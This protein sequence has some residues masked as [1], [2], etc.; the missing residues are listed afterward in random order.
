MPTVHTFPSL[1]V[2]WQL[3]NSPFLFEESALSLSVSLSIAPLFPISSLFSGLGRVDVGQSCGYHGLSSKRGFWPLLLPCRLVLERIS[4]RGIW[5]SQEIIFLRHNMLAV[6]CFF[7]Y[8]F[9][10]ASM[11]VP[12]RA[13]WRQITTLYA[14]VLVPT[15]GYYK[16]VV[17]GACE[18]KMGELWLEH[19]SLRRGREKRLFALGG[20]RHGIY[21]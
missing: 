9:C 12:H 21:V 6:F 10:M 5:S 17:G 7:K 2:D 18:A 8:T 13:W 16:T 20:Q 14:P 15:F 1:N 19:H 3:L 11:F 4:A